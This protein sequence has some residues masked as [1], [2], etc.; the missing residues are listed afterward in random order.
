MGRLFDIDPSD[1]WDLDREWEVKPTA[2]SIP[3]LAESMP[4]T[5]DRRAVVVAEDRPEHESC[6]AG[7]PG[8]CVL[9]ARC[10]HGCETW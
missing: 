8:C 6:E 1:R 5:L 10:E 2:A 4:D 9:H 7:T 3:T